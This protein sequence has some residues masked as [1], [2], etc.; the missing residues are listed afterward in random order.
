[1]QNTFS[2]S[3]NN[4]K[5]FFKKIIFQNTYVEIV[6][7]PPSIM[8]K[9]ILNFHFDYLTTSLY[10]FADFKNN[11]NNNSRGINCIYFWGWNLLH[12]IFLPLWQC[13]HFK[14]DG[15]EYEWWDIVV[16]YITFCQMNYTLF[17][18][19]SDWCLDTWWMRLH[20]QKWS[21]L[22]LAGIILSG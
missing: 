2:Q 16:I 5:W 10:Y 9:S 21:T 6:T 20:I 17:N 1:M 13:C 18:N 12:R 11:N 3:G 22:S 4:S 19:T 15:D 8:E 7:H 14:F